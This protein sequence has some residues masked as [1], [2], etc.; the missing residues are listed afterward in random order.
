M[1]LYIFSCDSIY[2]VRTF[3]HCIKM[4]IHEY[5]HLPIPTMLLY[6]HEYL[7]IPTKGQGRIQIQL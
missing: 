6:E 5:E 2:E 4:F 1:D 3:A 7:P